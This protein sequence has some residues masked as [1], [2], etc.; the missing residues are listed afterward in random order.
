LG[1]LNKIPLTDYSWPEDIIPNV[2]M[3]HAEE[4]EEIFDLAKAGAG[5]TPG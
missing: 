4:E 3:P 2:F 5:K 1:N